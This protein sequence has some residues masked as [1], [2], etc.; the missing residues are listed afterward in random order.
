MPAMRL[1]IV[2]EL[3]LQRLTP[4]KGQQSLDQSPGALRR[5]HPS[6]H[7]P[8]LPFAAHARAEEHIEAADDGGQKVIEVMRHTSGELPHG[9]QLLRLAQM[10]LGEAPFGDLDRLRHDGDDLAV[11]PPDWADRKV[12]A[13]QA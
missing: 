8:T 5:L 12:E 4:G 2:D 11:S 10:F 13:A 6:V 1:A 9:F 7:Q 3:D